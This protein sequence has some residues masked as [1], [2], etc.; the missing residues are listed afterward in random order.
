MKFY[1]KRDSV[2]TFSM[3][4]FLSIF[5]CRV[6]LPTV[7][8]CNA[9][10]IHQVVLCCRFFVFWCLIRASHLTSAIA[11]AMSRYQQLISE[12]DNVASQGLIKMTTLGLHTGAAG[13]ASNKKLWNREQATTSQIPCN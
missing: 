2:F 7:P 13:R 12:A 11:I 5:V 9:R 1:I 4:K 3:Y 6:T 10:S 8:E